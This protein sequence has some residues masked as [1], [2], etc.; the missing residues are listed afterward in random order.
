VVADSSQA[1]VAA[2]EMG[3]EELQRIGRAARERVL[4]EHTVAQR[5]RYLEQLLNDALRRPA[6]SR[7]RPQSV[8]GKTAWNV[9]D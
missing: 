4:A 9:P 2:I 7:Q 1:A 3:D 5:A 6:G 8:R